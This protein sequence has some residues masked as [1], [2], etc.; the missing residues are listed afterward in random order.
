MQNENKPVV[1]DGWDE[2]AS[3]KIYKHRGKIGINRSL[4]FGVFSFFSISMQG[5]VGAWLMFFYTTFCGLSAGQGATIFLVGRV[6]DAIASLLMGN[7]SDGIYKYKIGRKYGRRHLFILVAAPSVLVAIFMWVA[8][9][10]YLYYMLTYVV[11]TVLMSVLQIPWET[12]PNEMTKDYNE[13][14][15]LSTTRMTIAGLG[16]MLVQFVPA[17]LFKFFPKTSPEPYLIMQALF[18][19]VTFFLIFIT[20]FTTWEHFVSKKEA[21]QIQAESK[22]ENINTG[23]L[24]G[25]LKNYFSTFKIKSF[26]IHM[27]IY[28]SSYFAT[29]LF[30]TV[31][32]YYIV[33][34]LGKSTSTSGFLQSLS[35]LAIPVTIIAGFVITKVSPRTVYTFGYSLI[36][37]SCAAWAYVGLSKPSFMMTILVIGMVCYEIGLAILYFVP[38]NIF[39]F[40]PDLDTL[41]TGKNRSGLFASVMVFVN[42]ISQGLASVVAGYLLDFGGFR[43]STSGAVAQPASATN[44]ILF[45]VSGGVGFMILLA[46]IFARRFKLSK[47]T[48]RVLATEL[49]RLQKGGSMKDADD[50][51]KQVCEDLTGVPY[52]SLTVWKKNDADTSK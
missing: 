29:I 17:Q 51:T 52:D 50:H 11:T 44:M 7:F 40:I 15:T 4:G 9:M 41:I 47:K 8:N 38:W 31:F 16:N 24:K 48:F 27:G 26:R 45:I 1:H 25:E 23:S 2:Y 37:V 49:T 28:L 35:V 19:G 33:F 21:K 42:Q 3:K 30:S 36:L 14:T 18:S 20:Y 22:R 43:Q 46:L 6:A 34:V 32:V 39:P 5:L 10:S 13:R 12:L